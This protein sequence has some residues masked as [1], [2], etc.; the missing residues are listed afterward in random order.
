MYIPGVVIGVVGTL[1][2]EMAL[3]LIISLIKG[4]KK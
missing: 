3:V 2:V 1:L 4:G